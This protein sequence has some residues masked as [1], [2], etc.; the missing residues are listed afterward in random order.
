M[1][2]SLTSSSAWI[3][4]F[5]QTMTRLKFDFRK[6]K[7][8]E[9]EIIN[10]FSSSDEMVRKDAA[11]SF[12]KTLKDNIFNFTFIMNNISPITKKYYSKYSKFK[13][14]IFKTNIYT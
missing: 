11:M 10:L 6:K 8:S 14:W 7:L 12:G 1:E 3:K 4:F 2:K 9:T 5:D 13:N